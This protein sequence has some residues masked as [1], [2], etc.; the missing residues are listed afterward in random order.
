[1]LS[2]NINENSLMQ[3]KTGINSQKHNRCFFSTAQKHNAQLLEHN[4]LM[5]NVESDV[6]LVSRHTVTCREAQD[7]A[8]AQH[9]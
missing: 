4:S 3:Y 6:Y 7:E 8:G 1:M 2:L 5:P 9:P